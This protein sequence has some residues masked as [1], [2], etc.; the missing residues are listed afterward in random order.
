[1]KTPKAKR[2]PSGS[3]TC[4][5]RI[6]GQD[7]SI[8]KPTE[9]EAV[10]AAMAIKAGLVQVTKTPIADKIS[11]RVLCL[12]LYEELSVETANRS[13]DIIIALVR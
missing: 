9:K 2:L 5:V 12:P 11:Q 1:M 10:A 7:I 3:W 8:T 13:C 6:D 4:R